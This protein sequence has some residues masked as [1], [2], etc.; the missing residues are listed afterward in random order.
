M[1]EETKT[2][3]VSSTLGAT[4][5]DDVDQVKQ[6]AKWRKEASN[7]DKRLS[8]RMPKNH[9]NKKNYKKYKINDNALFPTDK[10]RGKAAAVHQVL[11]RNIKKYCIYDLYKVKY[12]VPG[13]KIFTSEHFK[14]E[15]IAD[16]P[17]R[18]QLPSRE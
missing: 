13:T 11:L 15:D 2:I 17:K 10:K 7:V 6:A 9:E 14:V 12:Q 18:N 16:R 4:Q 5:E 3:H 8:Q 1:R